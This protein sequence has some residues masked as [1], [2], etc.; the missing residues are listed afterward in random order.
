MVL[1]EREALPLDV[2][3]PIAQRFEEELPLFHPKVVLPYPLKEG[4][5]EEL[6]LFL[7]FERLLFILYQVQVLPF[8]PQTAEGLPHCPLLVVHVS[9]DPLLN[10]MFFLLLELDILLSD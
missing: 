10:D 4:G 6:L 3:G 7:L 1:K 2:L 9:F 8:L 5:G